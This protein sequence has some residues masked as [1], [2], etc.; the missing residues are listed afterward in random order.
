MAVRLEIN[1]RC[2]KLSSFKAILNAE[3]TVDQKIIA[4]N[5]NAYA[6]LGFFF[7]SINKLL[8]IAMN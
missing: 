6:F 3:A 8:I 2:R 5:A 1:K 7:L 4:S